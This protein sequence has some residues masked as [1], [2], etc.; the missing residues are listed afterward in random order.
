M[1]EQLKSDLKL[2][3]TAVLQICLTAIN[4]YQ[5][6]HQ[7]WLG[8]LFVGFGIS[9]LWTR[10]VNKVAFGVLRNRI[11]YASG[12]AVGTVIGMAIS[13]MIYSIIAW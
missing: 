4:M 2:F 5:V 13:Y 9:W 10:N 3:S 12:A 1:T 6:S 7:K 8:A 11:V